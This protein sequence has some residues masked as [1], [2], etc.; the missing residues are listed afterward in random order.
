M[1]PLIIGHRGASGYLPENTLAAFEKAIALGADG[2][3]LDIW[4]DA[5]GEPMVIHDESLSRTTRHRGKVTAMPMA[6][7]IPL[8]IPSYRQVLGIAPGKMVVFTELKGQQENRV[9]EA[10]YD[11]AASGAWN[12]SQLPVIGFDHAQLA[13][14]KAVYPEIAIGL[15]FD[16]AMLKQVPS[17]NHMI[18]KARELQA[19]AINPDY[20][21]A[22]KELVDAAH[23]AGLAVNVWTV[24]H[25]KAMQQMIALGVDA[26]M[27]DYPDRLHVLLQEA[28]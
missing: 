22:T 27:T 13:R 11:A 12:Y 19:A 9:G 3:E 26:I 15:S 1:A 25:P 7:L 28:K 23:A 10:I 2:I 18:A 4:P 14:L 8:G 20:H 16:K 5:S 24:N 17:A 21:L 6:D